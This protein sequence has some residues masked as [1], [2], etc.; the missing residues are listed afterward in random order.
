MVNLYT[1]GEGDPDKVVSE[2]ETIFSVS[3]EDTRYAGTQ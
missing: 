3:T 1:R 2:M